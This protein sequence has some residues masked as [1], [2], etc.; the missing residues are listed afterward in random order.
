MALYFDD[1]L[2]QGRDERSR[3]PTTI[4]RKEF[5]KNMRQVKAVES[6]RSRSPSK[7]PERVE[8]LKNSS[9]ANLTRSNMT[10]SKVSQDVPS[11]F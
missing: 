6:P 9:S 10:F 1:N 11:K 7:S 4:I 2:I 3:G 5:E 8:Q